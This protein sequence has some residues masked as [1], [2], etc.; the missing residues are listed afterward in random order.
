MQEHEPSGSSAS[1]SDENKW[2]P[3]TLNQTDCKSVIVDDTEESLPEVFD[4]DQVDKVQQDD[5]GVCESS[6]NLSKR[7]RHF[8]EKCGLNVCDLCSQSSRRLSKMDKKEYRVCDK[9][10]FLMSNKPFKDKLVAEL[11]RKQEIAKF[12]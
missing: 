8:C 6:F 12:L 2:N 11:S 10:D 5:C 1:E 7:Q 9:C 4:L 3:D